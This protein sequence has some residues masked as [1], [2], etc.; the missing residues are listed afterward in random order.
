MQL[1]RTWQDV[2][3]EET[4]RQAQASV[5]NLRVPPINSTIASKIR[6]DT[7]ES[8]LSGKNLNGDG[9]AEAREKQ[10]DGGNTQESKIAE[11]MELPVKYPIIPCYSRRWEKPGSYVIFSVSMKYSDGPRG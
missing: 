3:L 9:L 1:P 5:S 10:Q 2:I 11:E 6:G 4:S 7:L 8:P